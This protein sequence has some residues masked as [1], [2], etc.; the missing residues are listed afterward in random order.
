VIDAA[1]A[2]S[3][4]TLAPDPRLEIRNLVPNRLAGA[5]GVIDHESRIDIF[6]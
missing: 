4:P 3:C 1:G 2:V 5:C 6:A